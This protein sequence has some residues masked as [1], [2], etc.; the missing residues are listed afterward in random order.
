MASAR[1][2]AGKS[3]K[4]VRHFLANRFDQR[5][6]RAVYKESRKTRKLDRLFDVRNSFGF[7]YGCRPIHRENIKT[8]KHVLR[9]RRA[10]ACRLSTASILHSARIVYA[11]F[12]SHHNDSNELYSDGH[13]FCE[14]FKVP[15]SFIGRTL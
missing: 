3:E 14:S 12:S 13:V 8:R 10:S 11:A 5:Q 4:G 15:I 1:Q 6:R 9:H 2:D 7:L